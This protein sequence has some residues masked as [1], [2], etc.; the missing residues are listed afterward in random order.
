MSGARSSDLIAVYGIGGL[1][2]VALQYRIAGASVAA[3]DFIDSKL[4]MAAKLG[5]EYTFNA[6]HED[7]VEAIQAMGGADVAIA[8]AISPGG[9]PAGLPEPETGRHPG[10]GGP[11]RRQLHGSSDLRDRPSRHPRR[12]FRSWGLAETFQLHPKPGPTSCARRGGSSR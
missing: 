5:A 7:P 11:S 2:H 1:G 12:R 6:R 10:V 3:I 9:L 8:V 4:D